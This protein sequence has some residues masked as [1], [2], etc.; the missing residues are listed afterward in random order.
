MSKGFLASE[1]RPGRAGTQVTLESASWGG[2]REAPTR[3]AGEWVPDQ[4]EARAPRAPG[5][6]AVEVPVV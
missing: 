3:G 5:Q 6:R 2:G 4:G 1:D